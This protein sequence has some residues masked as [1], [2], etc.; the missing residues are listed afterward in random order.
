MREEAWTPSDGEKR[1]GFLIRLSG[2][3]AFYRSMLRS[4]SG[5]WPRVKSPR[6]KSDGLVGG[7]S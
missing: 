5:K 2:L 6:V 3:A 7:G 1:L 4:D